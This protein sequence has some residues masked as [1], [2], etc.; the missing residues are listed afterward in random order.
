MKK[1]KFNLLLQ[2][3]TLCL[4]IAAIAIGV[5]S[6][7]TASLNVSGTIGFEAHNVKATISA[8]IK[9][10]GVT[11]STVSA[12]GTPR[13]DYATIGNTVNLTG[14]ETTTQ[15][16]ALTKF[17]FSDMGESG[18]PADIYLK[19]SVTNNSA[20]N[21]KVYF[22]VPNITGVTAT[23]GEG[24][25]S[26]VKLGTTDS[27][28]SG[29]IVLKL[30]LN[31]NSSGDYDNLTTENN[32][33]LTMHLEKYEDYYV[34]SITESV[35][36]TKTKAFEPKETSRL[37]T[38]LGHGT[39]ED[40]NGAEFKQL[41]WYAFAVKGLDTGKGYMYNNAFYENGTANGT[42]ADRWYT[43]YDVNVNNDLTITVNSTNKSLKGHQLWFIQ[44][45]T[46][47]GGYMKDTSGSNF[48][49]GKKFNADDSQTTANTYAN[50]TYQSDIYK[51]LN[52][53]TSNK[54][55]SRTENNTFILDTGI[56]LDKNYSTISAALNKR[57]VNETA[58]TKKG[59]T[60]INVTNNF[61]S[62]FWLLNYTE[63]GL[64]YNKSLGQS[65]Y[66]SIVKNFS[67][68]KTDGVTDMSMVLGVAWWL[69]SP[70]AVNL[71]ALCVNVTGPFSTMNVYT[72][73]VGV[74]AAFQI[75]I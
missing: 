56:N 6:A 58:K 13:T 66:C 70:D 75:Q 64:A 16:L 44:Q 7:K 72:S 25:S 60:E 10:D 69:R 31:K 68:G 3:A 42:L 20:F 63:L 4:C 40:L 47:G 73:V 30:S 32:L 26:Y 41:E 36:N 27:D 17:Y 49:T 57:V 18:T 5:Y 50:A 21:I 71:Q 46:V 14:T 48:V 29:N 22:D 9:G 67:I 15:S 39:K 45:Y 53:D 11:G 24:S 2:I 54:C 52:N 8:Q 37:C 51:Y 35:Y 34:K 19:I 74:R 59:S 12:D 62:T 33:N 38:Q 1:R 28:K 55:D 43:L 23:I 61:A 65:N